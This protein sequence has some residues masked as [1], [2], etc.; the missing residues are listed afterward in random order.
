MKRG[1]RLQLSFPIYEQLCVCFRSKGG[2][3]EVRV[4]RDSEVLEDVGPDT[5]VV[6]SRKKAVAILESRANRAQRDALDELDQLV[7]VAAVGE[8]AH[9]VIKHMCNIAFVRKGNYLCT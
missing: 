5:Q 9:E 4:S 6:T 2:T 8:L 7:L 3:P 1:E